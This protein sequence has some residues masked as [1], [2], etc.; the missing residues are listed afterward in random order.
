MGKSGRVARRPC[1]PSIHVRIEG[2]QN[3]LDMP[4]K[5]GIPKPRSKLIFRD[6]LE[7]SHGVVI[8]VLPTPGRKLLENLLALLVPGPPQIARKNFQPG[9]QLCS[10]IPMRCREICVQRTTS[11][12]GIQNS[13]HGGLQKPHSRKLPEREPRH[14]SNNPFLL[15]QTPWI[16]THG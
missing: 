9:Q 8:Q 14:P 15:I 10:F 3:A 4:G 16:R 5:Y 2:G 7:D 12:S 1:I 6:I 13:V 11:L